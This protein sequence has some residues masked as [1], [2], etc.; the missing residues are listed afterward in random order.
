M[1]MNP[2]GSLVCVSGHSFDLSRKGYLNLLLSPSPPAYAKELFESRRRVCDA[3]FYD[4]LITAFTDV[5][6][7][8]AQPLNKRLTVLD[9]GC[10]EGSH[11]S[12]ISMQLKARPNCCLTG[13][14]IS[15]ESI[16]LA[17]AMETD[18]IWCVADLAKLPF[19]DESF[20]MIFNI[21]SPANYVEFTRLLKD[22]GIVLKV[23]PGSH[24]L[25]EIR[26]ALYHG[27][28]KNEYSGENIQDYFSQ[29]LEVLDTRNIRYTFEAGADILPDIIRMTPLTRDVH[30]LDSLQWNDLKSITVDL[31]I[32]IGRK[33]G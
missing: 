3:G 14:D 33:P 6:Q 28:P 16:Q 18:I 20:D 13:V 27:T 7:T 31:N 29:K 17:S 30:N 25:R 23:I 1:Q 2:S 5:I 26:E 21:L 22:D 12:K 10:G 4:P 32:L 11:L 8:F 24:Y 9:A 15:K 19:H